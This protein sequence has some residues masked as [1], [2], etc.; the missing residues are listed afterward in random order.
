MADKILFPASI[1]GSMPRPDF[2]KDLIADD[3]PYSDDEYRRLMGAAIRSVVALQEAAGLDVIS[4]GEWWRK[5]YIGVI[6]ELAHGFELSTNPADGR[7]WTVVV[8]KLSPKQPGFIAKEV[9]FLKKLTNRQIKATLPAPALLGERM[10]DESVS[11][12]AYPT[13]EAFVRDCV[14]I[15]RAEIEALRDE[16][17]S[18][19]QVDD[20]HLCLFVDPDVRS[21]YENPDQAA[22]FAVD[23]DNQVVAGF[24]DVRL[25]V[26]L[27]RRAGARAR[28]E[29]QH[30]GGYEP[31][32]K[33]LKRLD[34]G[35]IT[36]EFTT[37]G[38]GEM[39][40]FR[41]LPEHVEIGLGCVSTL[42]GLVDS[43]ETIVAR[44]EQALQHVAP[45]RITLNP[46]CGFAPGSAA[47]VSV[48]E[49]YLKLKNQVAAAKI[50]RERYS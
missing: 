21:G 31:I 32:M 11:S 47:V 22:D 19:I 50:L 36:M 24:D 4:D 34:V 15:L 3:C 5:S 17:V 48:D 14:P 40:V 8:D 20:P 23:M 28:G 49:V 42:P 1:I 43:V 33:Q 10:W 30:Q 6:A 27:C 25:A 45:E 26:H 7:P 9:A 37:P 12:K 46:E 29:A 16:G 13:R 2:V 35:H 38:S 41:E 39:S 44:V 18:I